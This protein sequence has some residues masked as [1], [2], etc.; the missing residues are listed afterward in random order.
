MSTDDDQLAWIGLRRPGS[1]TRTYEPAGSG[2]DVDGVRFGGWQ[3]H[4]VD[5][6]DFPDHEA[7]LVRVNYDLSPASSGT[8]PR[9][10]TVAFDFG[11]AAVVLDAV[12]RSAHA[13]LSPEYAVTRQLNFAPAGHDT[14]PESRV[15]LPEGLPEAEA[16]GFGGPVVSFRHTADGVRPG[17][18]AAWLSLLAGRGRAE[19]PVNVRVTFD[20]DQPGDG[21]AGAASFVVRLPARAS[22]ATQPQVM[23]SAAAAPLQ[24]RM[25]FV[26]DLVG[27]TDRTEPAQRHAQERIVDLTYEVVEALGVAAGDTFVQPTGDGMN[28]FLP[29]DI[30]Y[31]RVLGELRRL[32]VEH[33]VVDNGRNKDRLRFRM[34]VDVGPCRL[35]PNGCSGATIVSFGRL[36][37]TAKLRQ[38]MTDH[39]DASLGLIVSDY[40][41]SAIVAHDYPGLP[42]D[43][44]TPLD[45]VVK[46]YQARAWLW[47]SDQ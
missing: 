44:F 46:G 25:G 42:P 34:A 43:D 30:D 38:A 11:G 20:H 33:L 26:I 32:F 45:A 10:V 14:R 12:P 39:P 7:Y 31:S 9:A 35:A 21:A 17:A 22:R 4:S 3:L 8:V 2:V 47:V 27:Y 28:V 40:V 1:G 29:V 16:S 19:L 15:A 6:A 24:I 41:Y 36:V 23:R 37:E 5:A 13:A 18:R